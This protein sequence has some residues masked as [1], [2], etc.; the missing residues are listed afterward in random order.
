M[1]GPT[2]LQALALGKTGRLLFESFE[3]FNWGQD[4]G[5]TILQ[6]SP[7]ASSDTAIDGLKSLIMDSSFPQIEKDLTTDTFGYLAGWF[8]DDATETASTFQPFLQAVRTPAT[9]IFGLG[10]DNV[11]STTHYTYINA[12]AKVASSVARTT[13]WRRFEFQWITPNYILKIDGTTVATL[14]SNTVPWQKARVGAANAAGTAFGYFD[15]IQIG[16]DP[17]IT[18]RGLEVGQKVSIFDSAGAQVGSTATAAG[19][20][21]TINVAAEDQPMKGAYVRITRTDGVNPRFRSGGQEMFAGDSWTLI[22]VQV[23]RQPGALDVKR[24]TRREDT[25]AISGKQQTVLFNSRDRGVIAINEITEDQRHQFLA[26]WAW[27]QRGF[28][29]SVAIDVDNVYNGE[30]QAAVAPGATVLSVDDA[31]GASAGSWMQL[32]RTDN[33]NGEEVQIL[34]ISGTNIT[35]TNPLIFEYR[36][37]DTLRSIR[38][39][40]F[41]RAID[42]S[43]NISLANLRQKRWNFAHTFKEDL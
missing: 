39:W 28:T 12:G 9:T 1:S 41:V 37:S 6:G 7:V 14:A 27:A 34:S 38:Y 16:S 31:A 35:L 10:V 25:E 42:K 11:T 40:P 29:Y 32:R 5:W 26:W 30:L 22:E 17:R 15:F 20:S 4:Q 18:V 36:L 21:V 8:F 2:V 3:G 19:A 23:G 13:G 33:L 24:I 43:K